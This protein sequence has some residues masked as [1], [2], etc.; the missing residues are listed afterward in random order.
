MGLIMRDQPQ[1]TRQRHGGDL[2]VEFANHLTL[3]LEVG[4][5]R[6]IA[7]GGV[8]VEWQHDDGAQELIERRQVL[9]WLRRLARRRP[10]H[11]RQLR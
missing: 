9:R 6:A 5:E 2:H 10:T 8:F 1:P 4:L 7:S 3:A 11:L